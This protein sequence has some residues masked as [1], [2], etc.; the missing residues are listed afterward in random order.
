MPPLRLVLPRSLSLSVFL[1]L[2]NVCVCTT[3]AC[4]RACI[5]RV[6]IEPRGV[7]GFV[8]TCTVHLPVLP[9]HDDWL[10]TTAGRRARPE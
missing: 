5:R 4:V 1:S 2:T 7:G 6:C 9:L 3:C 10:S 8:L